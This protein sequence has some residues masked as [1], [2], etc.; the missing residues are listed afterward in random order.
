MVS[1]LL[2]VVELDAIIVAVEVEVATV[3]VVVKGDVGVVIVLV[4][5]WVSIVVI[6][7]VV[8]VG[9]D[10]VVTKLVVLLSAVEEVKVELVDED[11]DDAVSS[12][13]S[14]I[15]V[16]LVSILVDGIDVVTCVL[17]VLTIWLVVELDTK[18]GDVII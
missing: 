17:V 2:V 9:N 4:E 7:T 5:D 15:V 11:D 8:D 14:S 12:V 13:V 16:V 1:C 6:N 18:V 3:L 10:E